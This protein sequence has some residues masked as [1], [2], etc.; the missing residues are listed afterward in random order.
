MSS[1]IPRKTSCQSTC[2][3]SGRLTIEMNDDADIGEAI[4]F[5][6]KVAPILS[7]VLG[8]AKPSTL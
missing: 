6:L 7:G 4:V 1:A 3:T 2:P 5:A 8:A